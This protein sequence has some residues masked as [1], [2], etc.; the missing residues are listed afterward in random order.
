MEKALDGQAP[1]EPTVPVTVLR[2]DPPELDAEARLVL[3]APPDARERESR[4]VNP[5]VPLAYLF[6]RPDPDAPRADLTIAVGHYDTENLVWVFS[7]E[8][9][10]IIGLTQPLSAGRR[11]P[12]EE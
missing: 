3:R 12:A 1:P 9:D 6:E 7:G 11:P 5:N 8:I 10:G 2:L 4:R